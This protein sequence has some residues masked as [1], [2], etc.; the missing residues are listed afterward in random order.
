MNGERILIVAPSWVGD[1]I[2]SEP[3][4]ALLREP[5]EDPVVDV[6]APPWCA[7]VY[8]RM[9][10]V[11]RIIESPLAHGKLDL[12]AR[13]TL[14]AE[15]RGNGYTRAILLPNSWKSALV[16]FLAGI[17][18]RTGYRGEM[19]YGVLNDVRRLDRKA[20]PRRSARRADPATAG[21]GAGSRPRQPQR[22]RARAAPSHGQARGGALPRRRVRPGEALAAHALRRSRGALP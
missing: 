4:V 12:R 22:R 2:L 5:F 13:R 9:R 15:L 1:A 16:P 14:A 8:S 21:A 10:G 7:A 19:R 6:L 17:P 18:H 20:M 3:L 11:R